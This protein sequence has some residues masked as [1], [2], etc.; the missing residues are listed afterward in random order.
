MQVVEHF[1][2]RV[3]LLQNDTSSIKDRGLSKVKDWDMFINGWLP[4][5][6]TT[7][8]LPTEFAGSLSDFF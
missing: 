2:D 3:N 4:H 5:Q 1:M 8:K 7:D 6:G